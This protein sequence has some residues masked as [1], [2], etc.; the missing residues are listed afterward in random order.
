MQEGGGACRRTEGHAG[1][2]DS[3]QK[4]VRQT[5]KQQDGR[6][7]GETDG[8]RETQRDKWMDRKTEGHRGTGAERRMG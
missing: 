3:V 5:D 6:M 7:D 2:M 8:Q 1:G 4:A